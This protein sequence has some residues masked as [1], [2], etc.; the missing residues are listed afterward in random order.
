[1]SSR[2]SDLKTEISETNDK[3]RATKVARVSNYS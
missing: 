2:I 3:T 1:M